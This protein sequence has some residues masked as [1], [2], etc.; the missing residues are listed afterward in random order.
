MTESSPE[1]GAEQWK[2]KY[3]D[4]LDRLDQKEE[5]WSKLESVLK[6][7]IGRLSL[8]AE[9][10]NS[11]IDRHIKDVRTAIKD[12]INRHRLDTILDDL[13]NLLAKIEEKQAAPDKQTV[14]SLLSLI[15]A[16][17]LPAQ[18]DKAK[19]KLIKR[20]NKASDDASDSLVKESVELLKL[21]ITSDAN[22][23]EKNTGFFD[24]LLGSGNKPDKA[25]D[26]N[27]TATLL[28]HVIG[29][30]PWPDELTKTQQATDR[31]N[32][33]NKNR[34]RAQQKY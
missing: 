17:S 13:S 4:Q 33:Q 32:S 27:A 30:L 3:Y 20:L 7:A 34:S 14:S 29:I 9:G 2:K 5:E 26:F 23:D 22:T 25:I 12:K 8:A 16:L 21:A 19:K 1:Q 31:K 15:E 10:H 28:G 18:C 11:S 6:R 24:R